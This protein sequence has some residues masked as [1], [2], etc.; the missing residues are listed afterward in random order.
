VNTY[1][2]MAQSH[3]KTWLPS[4]YAAIPNPDNFFSELGTEVSDRIAGL[5]LE[6]LEPEQPGEEF[7]TRVGRRNMARLQAEELVL[8]EMV[9]L[10]PE[11]G[12]STEVDSDDLPPEWAIPTAQET[13]AQIA[14]ETE[15]T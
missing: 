1:G 2:A 8:R 13:V 10:P 7:L 12:T 5:E 15:T 14:A 3:W 6:L 9:L 4:R 11:K